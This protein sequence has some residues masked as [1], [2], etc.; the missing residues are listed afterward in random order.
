MADKTVNR[1]VRLYIDGQEVENSAKSL[2]AELRRLRA[3]QNKMT[4]GSEAYINKGKEIRQV[5]KILDEHRKQWKE[6]GKAIDEDNE[7]IG[8]FGTSIASTIGN[9]A[10]DKLNEFVNGLKAVTDES[11]EL[12]S[13][14]DGVRHAFEELNRPGLLDQLREETHGTISDLNLMQYALTAKNLNVPIENMGKYLAFA[15]KRA[16][17]MGVSVDYLAESIVTGI[18]RGSLMIL[19][20]LG[21]GAKEIRDNMKDGASMADAVAKIIDNDL[22]ASGEHYA[23]A[24]EKAAQRTADLQ[25]AQEELGRALIPI[26]SEIDEFYT[27]LTKGS[28]EAIKW[29]VQNK[30]IVVG[31]TVALTAYS[32]AL[33][34]SA[35]SAKIAAAAHTVL[36]A[37]LKLNPY[38]AVTTAVLGIAAGMLLWT[39][40]TE[41]QTLA[42]KTLNSV[43]EDAK[44]KLAETLLEENRLQKIIHSST[45]TLKDKKKAVED[46]KKIVPEYTAVLDDQGKVVKE[47]TKAIQLHN[48][49]L[50]RMYMIEGAKGKLK[51]LAAQY[52][53]V[54]V[55]ITKAQKNLDDAMALQKNSNKSLL[56]FN[57]AQV[58]SMNANTNQA[59][60]TL[61]SLI[62]QQ[63]EYSDAFNALSDAQ[64]EWAKGLPEQKEI[65]EDTKKD[66][67]KKTK[68]KSAEELERERIQQALKDIDLK[69]TEERTT[70]TR[71]WNEGQITDQEEYNN[72]IIDNEKQRIEEELGLIGISNEQKIQLEQK[73]Q[74]LIKQYKDKCREE[75][76]AAEEEYQ[77]EIEKKDK[78]HNDNVEKIWQD[79]RDRQQ[80]IAD[81][82]YSSVSNLIIST[83]SN[84]GKAIGEFIQ[85]DKKAFHDFLKSLIVD[86][87]DA[88][89][90]IVMTI[91]ATNLAKDVGEIGWAG[92][93]T[94]AAKNALIIGAFEAAKAL[95]NS[96]YSGGF[97]GPGEWDQP[98]GIV[99]SN[100]FVSNRFATQNPQVRPVLN[101]I[102]QAQKSGSAQNLTAE[103]IVG[104]YAGRPGMTQQADNTQLMKTLMQVSVA[105]SG[106]KEQMKQPIIAQTY[107]TGKGGVNEAQELVNRMNKNVS[108]S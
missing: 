101:L 52:A 21:L 99:H 11:I 86:V 39:K 60:S 22:A 97:T 17:E 83:M 98:Q 2:Q 4:I 53:E 30:E 84:A 79:H 100:E 27:T 76:L 67:S 102:D 74:D 61:E 26:K 38:V 41:E 72:L 7:K 18:G 92:V 3:E 64:K 104:V 70:I 90:K 19:D 5:N 50:L 75:D 44:Q 24:A 42:Q 106:L 68:G 85:G 87:I 69:Y 40:R 46:L 89:E 91:T 93:A 58:A 80:A 36:N 13:K 55:K 65:K 25:N 56:S 62:K 10:A 103:D 15:Q 34:I 12:A 43:Q 8:I 48:D 107:A 78:K 71:L 96:F 88:A 59:K 16:A 49:Q 47:N 57:Q 77:K 108:R 73:I 105:V 82:L 66:K 95:A 31:L 32:T 28:I 63:K 1:T 35:N 54:T 37:V 45:A 33:T 9:F 51:E 29:M 81:S 14:A 94:A 23:S 20:N 6:T